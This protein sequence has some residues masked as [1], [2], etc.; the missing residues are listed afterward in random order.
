MIDLLVL[1]SWEHDADFAALLQQA[2]DARGVCMR[3]VGEAELKTLPAAL[4]SGDLRANCLID[5]VWDWGGDWEN[6]VPAVKAH[7]PHVLNPFELVRPAW[8]K[9]H[10]HFKLIGHGLHAPYLVIV[11]AV[12]N[13]PNPT[14]VDLAPLGGKFSI[15]SAHSGGSGV[16]KPATTWA[17]VL[18][19]RTEWP[20]DETLVQTWV[21]PRLLSLPKAERNAPETGDDL[22]PFLRQSLQTLNASNTRN[23][24]IERN[25]PMGV[26]DELPQ[27]QTQ[28]RAWFR[29]F[30]ACGSTFL[31]WQDDQ[32][33]LQTPVTPEEESRFGL[34]ALRGMVQ[35]IANICG[36]NLF[37]T[38]IAL[39]QNNVWQV[40]DYVNDPCDYRLQS[41]AREG[42]PDIV[43]KGVC[44]RIASW[45]KRKKKD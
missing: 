44:E 1:W 25:K 27:D 15:K 37:S 17:E 45:V 22:P 8:N 31:C 13:L 10:V 33:H 6:H 26:V 32:T 43:V 11:P 41:K 30:Y 5:R 9:P 38:E 24:L 2:C 40:V 35:Q 19:K 16:I 7:V 36:L 23:I 3:S 29:I 21:E 4:A 20:H 28:K 34:N 39:D 12:Q 14:E 42:V 18:A